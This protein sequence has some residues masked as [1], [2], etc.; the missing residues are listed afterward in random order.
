M[1]EV[2]QPGRFHLFERVGVELEYMIVDS[3]SLAVRP[4]A[5]KV[6]SAVGGEGA[7]EVE[8]AETAWSNELT[9]HVL[10]MKTVEPRGSLTALDSCFQHDVRQINTLLEPHEAR[11]MPTSM[12][13]WMDP[14]TETKLWPNAQNEI[15]EAYD[16]IFGVRGHGWANVQSSHINLPFA[17]EDEF[18]R[19]H[20]AIR[21]VL[22]LLPAIA[23]SSPIQ[24]GRVPGML[25]SRLMAYSMIQ[26]RVPSVTGRV[27]PESVH[28]VD[29]YH[30]K[31]L[32]KM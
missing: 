32:G 16:R 5:D 27:I 22:P 13:P 19:L 1:L 15:Y 3:E 21:V 30:T 26:Q 10:E 31:I 8:F 6:L 18:V 4:I 14:G 12:H 25:D 2:D 9:L 29:A 7:S 17:N 11:L 28:S 24:D 23:A 20:A